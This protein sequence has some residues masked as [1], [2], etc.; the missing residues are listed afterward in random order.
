MTTRARRRK[1]IDCVDQMNIRLE[2]A[3]DPPCKI[4]GGKT[5]KQHFC[6]TLTGLEKGSPVS[7]SF[8]NA[9]DSMC[10]DDW[11]GYQCV[12]ADGVATADPLG[13]G[14]CWVRIKSTSFDGQIL[15]VEHVPQSNSCTYAYF[16]PYT[17]DRHARLLASVATHSVPRCAVTTVGRVRESLTGAAEAGTSSLTLD[18][19]QID[20][21]IV[22]STTS[23]QNTIDDGSN[24][25]AARGGS[26]SSSTT[27]TAAS[28]VEGSG[29][30]S[31][32]STGSTGASS[33][34]ASSTA[35][36]SKLKKKVV[37]VVCRQHPAET[38]AE[39]WAEGFLKRLSQPAGA[40]PTVDALL[41]VTTLSRAPPIS[42]IYVAGADPTV[43]ALLYDA[44]SHWHY[45]N[46]RTCGGAAAPVKGVPQSLSLVPVKGPAI[47]V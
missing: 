14:E 32:T 27:T 37:W 47:I 23:T 46:S 5:F 11:E 22:S 17:L 2:L 25:S 4:E 15:K 42:Y 8:V 38:M 39:W 26:S 41:Y 19:R 7:I 36:S 13:D 34:G 33:T 16:A 45:P 18:G 10:A 3:C 12:Y 29:R 31:N 21:V 20:V 28:M 24:S 30:S 6:F 35:S 40:D 9:G 1:V 43:D 44:R